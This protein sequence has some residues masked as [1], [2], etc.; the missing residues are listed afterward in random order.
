MPCI[1]QN[2]FWACAAT[3]CGIIYEPGR[4]AGILFALPRSIAKPHVHTAL[5]NGRVPLA[6]KDTDLDKLQKLAEQV[7]GEG[8]LFLATVPEK[9][10][11]WEGG[12][13]P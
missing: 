6:P 5:T 2:S 7:F 10:L 3:Q 11:R 8:D 4:C 9:P 12:P 13:H 1:S